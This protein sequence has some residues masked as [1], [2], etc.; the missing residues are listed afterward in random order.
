MKKIPAQEKPRKNLAKLATKKMYRTRGHRIFRDLTLE[1]I[2]EQASPPPMLK[3]NRLSFAPKMT[4]PTD[5]TDKG[6]IPLDR[7]L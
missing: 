6:F 7:V 2:I 5:P 4:D 1:N 3:Y